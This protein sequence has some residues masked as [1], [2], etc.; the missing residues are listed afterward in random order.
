MNILDNIILS[1]EQVSKSYES[2]LMRKRVL[3]RISLNFS[4]GSINLIY[5][6][7]GSGKT[8]LLNLLAGLDKPTQGSI[9]FQGRKYESM[10]EKE[11]AKLRGINYGFVFQ[12]YHLIPRIS[13]EEN[14][15][16]PSYVNGKQIDMTYFQFLIEEL[17]IKPFV[18]K[19]PCKL[20][21]GEQ[22]RVAIARAMLLKPKIIFADE[23]TGNLDSENTKVITSLFQKLNEK[24]RTTFIIVTHEENLIEQ[25]EQVIQLKDGEIVIE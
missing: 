14:I 12:A 4:E 16:C 1:C 25:C 20:S 23:P 9:I 2:H 8:T 11:L 7:S 22:Q 3:N 5:G 15:L 21:G 19:L 10:K 17:G 24:Y 6:K 13:V 18:K